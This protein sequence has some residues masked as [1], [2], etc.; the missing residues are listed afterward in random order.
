MYLCSISGCFLHEAPATGLQN[1]S[2]YVAAM[3]LEVWKLSQEET[4]AET[5]KT[6][7]TDYL[8]RLGDEW[9]KREEERQKVFTQK[10]R[11][12]LGYACMYIYMH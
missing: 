8:R 5:M 6:K 7:G 12:Q 11:V 9:R 4:F 1:S 3:E 2:E 10:V